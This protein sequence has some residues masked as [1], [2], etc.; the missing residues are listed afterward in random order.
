[1]RRHVE[2]N[3]IHYPLQYLPHDLFSNMHSL[4]FLRVAGAAQLQTFPSLAGQHQLSTLVITIVRSLQQLPNM[5]DLTGLRTLI[6]AEATHVPV[7]PSLQ[8]LKSLSTF[9]L[10]RR[11]EVC[12]NGYATGYCDLT[13]FQCRKRADEPDVQCVD[14]RMPAEDH[15]VVDRVDGFLCGNN[16]TQDIDASEPTRYS[17][18]GI[19]EGV[20]YRECDLDGVRGICYNGRMQVVHCDVFG[21][22]EKMRRLQIARGVG[23]ACDPEVEA[24]LG[25]SVTR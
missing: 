9:T 21:E 19:C 20:L 24:W 8:H 18:D 22:Y 15:A 3:F 17:T 7:L 5:D 25:C 6:L 1:M 12:C 23:D 13:N 10:F 11:N 4:R 2:G 14:A 16:I